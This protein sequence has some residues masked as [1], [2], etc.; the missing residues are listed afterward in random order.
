MS[1]HKQAE[2]IERVLVH[3]S[4][5]RRGFL[6][7]LLA[8]SGALLLAPLMTSTAMAWSPEQ[9]CYFWEKKVKKG[10]WPGEFSIEVKKKK[11]PPEE[12]WLKSKGKKGK[13]FDEVWRKGKGK[14]GWHWVSDEF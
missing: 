11:C 8:G 5:N 9:E 4:D 3:V 12:F 6:R 10:R 2:L 7:R 1:S 14:K 13:R